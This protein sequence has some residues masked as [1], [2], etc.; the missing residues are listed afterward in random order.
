MQS[1]DKKE[2]L[3]I[4]RKVKKTHRCSS[5]TSFKHTERKLTKKKP[6]FTIKSA[7]AFLFS[8]CTLEWYA[9]YRSD[10]PY[11]FLDHDPTPF[12]F[13]T[14]AWWKNEKLAEVPWRNFERVAFESEHEPSLHGGLHARASPPAF[15]PVYSDHDCQQETARVGFANRRL[16]LTLI[17]FIFIYFL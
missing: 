10:A 3:C 5:R 7:P 16:Y 2:T 17:Y 8:H 9:F 14:R 1:I 6:C 12:L 15:Y 13:L 11:L 4:Q